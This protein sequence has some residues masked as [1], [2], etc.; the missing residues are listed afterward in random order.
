MILKGPEILAIQPKTNKSI[1][2]NSISIDFN[3]MLI[4]FQFVLDGFLIRFQLILKG[5]LIR[6][7]SVLKRILMGLGVQGLG[8]R[9]QGLGVQGLGF[10]VEGL[11]LC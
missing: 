1:S 11:R 7:Q 5:I 6:F 2:F 10:K 3:G 9:V 8:F 4:R